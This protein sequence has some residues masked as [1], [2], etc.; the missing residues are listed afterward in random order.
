MPSK[1]E[2]IG[3]LFVHGIGEQKQLDHLIASARELASLVAESEGLI[4]LNVRD[5]TKAEGRIVIDAT[6]ARD[7][8]KER[9]RL[10]LHEV[11]WADLG[12]SGGLGE[13]IRFWLWS[14]GQWAAQV[15]REG[16]PLRNTM[17]LM[18]IPRF[19]ETLN[20]ADEPGFGRRAPAR[21]V[22]A[23]AGVLAFLTLFSWSAAK[24]IVSFLSQSVPAPSLIF[25]FLGDVKNYEEG[26]RPG[27]GM[28]DPGQP[29]RATIRRR[30]VS[31]MTAMAARPDYGR[32]YIFAHSLGTVP[33]FNALQET[34]WTLPNYLSEAEWTALPDRFKTAS[35][36]TPPDLSIDN[37][38]SLDNMMPRRPP[39]IQGKTGIDRRQLFARFAGFVSYGSPLDKFAALWPR[40]VPLNRQVAVFPADCEWINLYDPTDPIGASLDAFGPPPRR[41]D[42]PV[43]DRIGLEPQS[44]ATRAGLIFGLSHIR[45][46]KPPRQGLSF[47]KLARKLHLGALYEW[48]REARRKA[49]ERRGAPPRPRAMPVAIVG[50]LVSGRRTTLADAARAAATPRWRV[51]ARVVL[52]ALQV[53]VL[54]VALAL[55]SAWLLYAIGKALPDSATGPIKWVLGALAPGL[56]AWLQA[57]FAPA[58]AAS[59]LIMLLLGLFAVGASGGM[60]ILADLFRPP[61]P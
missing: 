33:A 50:A 4:R 52:A 21:L 51:A 11:W 19:D 20:A 45:Y 59:G 37:Q 40:V 38:P 55:A 48:A 22:L 24:R 58:V 1:V 25:L 6:F 47:E 9:V 13:Q 12:I 27:K 5:E 18:D 28:L 57:G 54:A 15:V 49:R 56:L 61:H 44:F 39:W 16:N 17:K 26:G 32:W 2:D 46:F 60:R 41:A 10:Y 34:E 14:L 53:M 3:L 30:M 35:P 43:A 36:F 7:G 31:A 23:V 29:M 42:P 8:A